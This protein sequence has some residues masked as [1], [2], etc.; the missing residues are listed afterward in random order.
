[1]TRLRATIG[2]GCAFEQPGRSGASAASVWRP[3]RFVYT[4]APG[5]ALPCAASGSTTAELLL[6]AQ[7]TATPRALIAAQYREHGPPHFLRF[8]YEIGATTG[9]SLPVPSAGGE[10]T[11]VEEAR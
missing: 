7:T 3:V 4:I 2:V 9:R 11:S 8:C 10:G 1:M 6:H 5:V